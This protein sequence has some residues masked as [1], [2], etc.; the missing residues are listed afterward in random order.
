M[1]L[2]WISLNS[3]FLPTNDDEHCPAAAFVGLLGEDV[4]RGP[5]GSA[6]VPE[7]A[8]TPHVNHCTRS[9]CLQYPSK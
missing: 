5:G 9:P 4:I 3:H 8:N 1:R 7:T 6:A 2:I